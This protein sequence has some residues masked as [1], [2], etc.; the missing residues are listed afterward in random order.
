MALHIAYTYVKESSHKFRI[1][2]PVYTLSF[3]LQKLRDM[4]PNEPSK[5]TLHEQDMDKPPETFVTVI[6][7]S[8]HDTPREP[9][10][11]PTLKP[12]TLRRSPAA[13]DFISEAAELLERENV[14]LKDANSKLNNHIVSMTEENKKLKSELKAVNEKTKTLLA[15]LEKAEK[16]ANKSTSE[17]K[18]NEREIDEMVRE[19]DEE[20]VVM[21]EELDKRTKDLENMTIRLKNKESDLSRVA[22][23]LAVAN[24]RLEILEKNGSKDRQVS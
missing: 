3:L 17:L 11:G 18:S 2:I 16:C 9:P 15:K 24:N 21:K 10:R 19:R 5:N 13:K 14:Q 20:R 4:D 23:D 12:A 22:Y 6:R 1:I 7:G 8:S